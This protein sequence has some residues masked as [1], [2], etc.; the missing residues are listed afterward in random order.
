MGRPAG[1]LL[2]AQSLSESA[3]FFFFSFFSFFSLPSFLLFFLGAW[4]ERQ[5]GARPVSSRAGGC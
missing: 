2:W 3:F 1:R 5:A 4:S